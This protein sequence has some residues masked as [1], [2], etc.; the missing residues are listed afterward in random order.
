[1]NGHKLRFKIMGQIRPARLLTLGLAQIFLLISLLFVR[2][3]TAEAL[4]IAT[5]YSREDSSALQRGADQAEKASDQIYQGLDTTKR[6]IGKT[7]KRNQ[8]IQEGREKASGKLDDL[9]DKARSAQETGEPLP[10]NQQRIV[11]R[12]Q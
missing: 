4:P 1:M 11:D 8:I 2:P 3:A 5:F 12:L 6:I 10:Q 9:A 7:D